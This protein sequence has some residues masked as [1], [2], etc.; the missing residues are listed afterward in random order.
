MNKQSISETKKKKNS[1]FKIRRTTAITAIALLA[2]FSS[3]LLSAKITFNMGDVTRGDRRLIYPSREMPHKPIGGFLNNIEAIRSEPRIEFYRNHNESCSFPTRGHFDSHMRV[4]W[5]CGS[6]TLEIS[7]PIMFGQRTQLSITSAPIM[8]D[9]MFLLPLGNSTDSLAIVTKITSK[10][11]E[12][13]VYLNN[14]KVPYNFIPPTAD[15]PFKDPKKIQAIIPAKNAKKYEEIYFYAEGSLNIY[16]FKLNA[17]DSKTSTKPINLKTDLKVKH[18]KLMKIENFF[19]SENYITFSGYEDGQSFIFSCPGDVK[20]QHQMAGC[21]KEE[22]YKSSSNTTVWGFRQTSQ[23]INLMIRT[24]DKAANKSKMSI[25]YFESYKT[26]KANKMSDYLIDTSQAENSPDAQLGDIHFQNNYLR[27]SFKNK[28]NVISIWNVWSHSSKP[29]Q[30]TRTYFNDKRYEIKELIFTAPDFYLGIQSHYEINF[31]FLN[32]IFDPSKIKGI[33]FQHDIICSRPD[34]SHIDYDFQATVVN[35]TDVKF[36]SSQNL[37]TVKIKAIKGTTIEYNLPELNFRGNNLMYSVKS[38]KQSLVN[39]V[40]EKFFEVKSEGNAQIDIMDDLIGQSINGQGFSLHSCELMIDNAV[41]AN[42]TRIG[43]EENY[44]NSNAPKLVVLSQINT[45]DAIY[46]VFKGKGSNIGLGIY[47][48]VKS[49]LEAISQIDLKTDLLGDGVPDYVTLGTFQG[50]ANL[51]AGK[52]TRIVKYSLKKGSKAKETYDIAPSMPSSKGKDC[53]PIG[54]KVSNFYENQIT[55]RHRAYI[56]FNCGAENVI[57]DMRKPNQIREIMKY[58]TKKIKTCVTKSGIIHADLTKAQHMLYLVKGGNGEVI[59]Y[60]VSSFNVKSIT[61]LICDHPGE[62]HILATGVDKAGK[63][64][65]LMLNVDKFDPLDLIYSRFEDPFPDTIAIKLA[66]YNDYFI[67]TFISA[68]GERKYLLINC[69]D[70]EVIIKADET[71][72]AEFRAGIYGKPETDNDFV[73][74]INVET[75]EIPVTKVIQKTNKFSAFDKKGIYDLDDFFLP[76]GPVKSFKVNIPESLLKSNK[77]TLLYNQKRAEMVGQKKDV[78]FASAQEM[79]MDYSDGRYLVMR[80]NEFQTEVYEILANA[81]PVTENL[82]MFVQNSCNKMSYSGRANQGTV[83]MSCPHS[84][85]IIIHVKVQ[86]GKL[87]QDGFKYLEPSRVSSVVHLDQRLA[88]VAKSARIGTSKVTFKFQP[89][90][91]PDAKNSGGME[92]LKPKFSYNIE[93]SKFSSKLFFLGFVNN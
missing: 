16:Q 73:V 17:T 14:K 2:I 5:Y 84:S 51:Y 45:V 93:E 12:Y 11:G 61:N 46:S 57:V 79:S 80:S 59:D 27:L 19:V 63:K 50:V 47:Y 82:I 39:L 72:S 89:Y 1:V 31:K 77:V 70:K 26:P 91:V 34:G 58:D 86:N 37:K 23:H 64:V 55:L 65:V 20:A 92:F 66:R 41:K 40:A 87:V 6:K 7:N 76:S 18:E 33:S 88:V 30:R 36:A 52:G 25:G 21:L 9:V 56:T 29:P 60:E 71:F 69:F 38:P 8:Q 67:L 22:V 15:A 90:E 78:T 24:V 49:N 4:F 48:K 42:C 3:P 62:G 54:M 85:D 74:K 28:T 13:Q 81:T 43:K 75:Q 68:K 83:Y 53:K 35:P 44:A 32:F 10:P